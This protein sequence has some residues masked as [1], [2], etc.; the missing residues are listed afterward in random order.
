MT[1]ARSRPRLRRMAVICGT[2]AAWAL[3]GAR[4]LARGDR[5]EVDSG[6]RLPFTADARAS[7]VALTGV[8][9]SR[10]FIGVATGPQSVAFAPGRRP[11]TTANV[12]VGNVSVFCVRTGG[13][14][15]AA[16]W[17]PFATGVPTPVSEGA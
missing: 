1:A 10:F 4:A 17:S 3:T 16:P 12:N 6:F 7:L 13:E 14:L 15:T 9:G 2:V 5:A 8:L 11:L